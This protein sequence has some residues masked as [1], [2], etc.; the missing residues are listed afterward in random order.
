MNIKAIAMALVL[1]APAAQSQD[2]IGQWLPI[3]AGGAAGYKIADHYG[4]HDGEL[5]AGAVLGS[6]LASR[7]AYRGAYGAPVGAVYGAAP[8]GYGTSVGYGTPDPFHNACVGMIPP[9]Y[10]NNSGAA[11]AWVQGCKQRLANQQAEIEQQAYEA[12]SR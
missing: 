6:V 7:W 11:S 3:I 8:Y 1:V 10:Q 4:G 2:Y 12:G 5:A 9:A